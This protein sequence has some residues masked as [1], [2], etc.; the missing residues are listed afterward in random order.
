MQSLFISFEGVEGSGKSTQVGKL[1]SRLREMGCPLEVVRE[2]GGTRIGE[3]IRHITHDRENVDLTAV[4]EVYLMAASRA[5]LVREV[6]RPALDTGKIVIGDRF[7][8]SSLSYQGYGRE[9]GEEVVLQLNKLA[10]D[11]VFP[12][13]TF[14]LNI[15]PKEGQKRRNGSLKIDRLDLQQKEFYE[16]VYE[17]YKTLSQKYKDRYV[18][19]DASLGIDEVSEIIWKRVKPLLESL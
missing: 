8:D 4:S 17:G 10:L 3:A 19:I 13:L 11:G 12:T 16:R 9:M 14:L 18:V 6:I 7:I 5:Q 15:D 1:A 2:P